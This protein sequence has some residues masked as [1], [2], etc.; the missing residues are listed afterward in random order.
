MNKPH[1]NKNL[2]LIPAL[3]LL[4][5]IVLLAG[6]QPASRGDL[7]KETLSTAPA[8][9]PG[10]EADI[11][12]GQEP[13]KDAA[14]PVDLKESIASS[15]DS[16]EGIASDTDS[17]EEIA[18]AADQAIDWKNTL[19]LIVTANGVKYQPIPLLGEASIPIRNEE[20]GTENVVHVT[21]TEIHM[22]SASCANQDCVEQGE[23]TRENMN[24]RI[25]YNTIVCL[26]NQV[27]LELFTF[28]MMVEAFG[29]ETMEQ[30]TG[31]TN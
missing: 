10:A 29:A 22:E 15:T 20:A 6:R 31:V 11:A 28:D 3:V 14:S 26:P 1:L 25:L 5:V 19:F 12:S 4:A 23:V 2:L 9:T 30:A 21:P 16:A 24:E 18:S 13:G 17:N 7:P 27:M 8:E